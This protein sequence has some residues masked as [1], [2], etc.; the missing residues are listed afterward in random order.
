MVEVLMIIIF[1]LGYAVI[2]LEHKTGINKTAVALLTA[3]ACWALV[4]LQQG[5]A[6]HEF[7]MAKWGEHLQGAAQIVFFLIGAM[8]IVQL[9]ETHGGFQIV[10]RAITTRNKRALLWVISLITF[11][12]SAVLDNLTTAIVMTTLMSGLVEDKEDRLVFASMIIIAANAGGAWTPIGD[13]TTTML[14]IG[15]RVSSVRIMQMLLIPSFVA[16]LVPLVWFSSMIKAGAVAAPVEKGPAV[17]PGSRQVFWMGLSALV[18]VPVFKSLTG[19][20]PVAGMLLGLGVVWLATDLMHDDT[21]AHLKAPTALSKID[22]SS[23]LFFLGILLAVAALDTAGILTRFSGWMDQHWG[24]K[25]V[26][27]TALGFLSA[28]VDNVPLTA[29]TMGMY[30]LAQ[31]PTDAKLWELLAY[32]VGTGGSILIIGSAAGVVV[33][34]LARI[35][36]FWYLRR[37]SLIALIGYLAGIAAYLGIYQFFH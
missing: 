8:T 1:I 12:L 3:V 11:F 24:N 33:M 19:L 15:G 21:R 14:W 7:V 4:M 23:V 17:L 20:P 30:S 16:T 2:A 32:A 22:F 5:T 6:S 34:G 25:D 26:I 36:F 29:A 31:H 18:F 9:M 13:V 35:D 28:I 27:A 37:V 10:A